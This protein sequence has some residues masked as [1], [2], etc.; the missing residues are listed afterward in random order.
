MLVLEPKGDRLRVEL[1]DKS[2]RVPVVMSGGCDE[3]SGR[4]LHLLAAVS[5]DWGALL[6]AT[7]KAVW[8]EIALEPA[9]HCVRVRRA[10]ALLEEYRRA[11]G[12]GSAVVPTYAVLEASVT[13]VIAD[14]LH[15]L[16]V[17]GGDPD[18]VLDQAQIRYEAESEA[19]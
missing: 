3:R 8:C 16:A 15:W 7:G 6:T 19:A 5:L 13:D 11:V 18:D 10:A 4:G 12:E 9:R 1:H 17:Q 2:H 14:L